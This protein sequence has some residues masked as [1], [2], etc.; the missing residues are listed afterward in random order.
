VADTFGGT[1]KSFD[2]DRLALYRA[3]LPYF[4]AGGL[5]PENIRE[6]LENSSPYALDLNSKVE[7]APGKKDMEKIKECLRLIKV[8]EKSG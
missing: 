5:G 2:W 4:L 3:K 1:G 6:A 7:L 8:W